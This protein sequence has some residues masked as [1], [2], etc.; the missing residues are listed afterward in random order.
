MWGNAGI[1][2]DRGTLSMHRVNTVLSL[3]QRQNKIPYSVFLECF[4]VSKA[5]P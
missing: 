5:F 4:I 2:K 1:T 3:G